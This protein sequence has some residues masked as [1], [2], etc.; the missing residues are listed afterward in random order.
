LGLG[1]SIPNRNT[2][3][4]R[5]QGRIAIVFRDHSSRA[6]DWLPNPISRSGREVES[7]ISLLEKNGY[8]I[9]EHLA[10]GSSRII[11]GDRLTK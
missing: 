3:A 8:K 4:I 10:A 1:L 7:A 2:M 11:R 5:P 6:P 9:I